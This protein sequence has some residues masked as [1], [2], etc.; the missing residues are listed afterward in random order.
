M[1]SWRKI[2]KLLEKGELGRVMMKMEGCFK[3]EGGHFLK[4][5]FCMVRE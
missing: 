3:R 2:R 5:L 1:E 4:P